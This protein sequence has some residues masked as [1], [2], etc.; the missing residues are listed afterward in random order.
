MSS[1]A[2]LTKKHTL[3]NILVNVAAVVHPLTA[4][5][6]VFAI[7][8]TQIVTGISL[9]TWVGFMLIG[10]IFLAYGC[11]H[12]LRPII[13]TQVLWFVVDLLVIIGIILYR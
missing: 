13:V 4:L 9:L 7:Y 3:L 5:P 10:L 11:V 1:T 12:R 8:T 6:Q 2:S